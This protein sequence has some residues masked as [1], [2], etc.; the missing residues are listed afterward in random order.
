VLIGCL[1]L[2]LL[3]LCVTTG[4][5]YYGFNR[6]ECEGKKGEWGCFGWDD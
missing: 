6:G 1:L 5:K 4:W 3:L 2:L